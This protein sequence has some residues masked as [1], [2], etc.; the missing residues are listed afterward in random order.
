ME[1]KFIEYESKY[2]FIYKYK[3]P[4]K[5]TYNYNIVNYQDLFIGEIK[6]H[7]QWRKYCFFPAPNTLWDEKCLNEINVFLN[8]I[9]L[10]YKASK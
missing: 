3:E 5:K 4:N 6:W 9:T 7:A 1:N 8:R 10:E 2:F